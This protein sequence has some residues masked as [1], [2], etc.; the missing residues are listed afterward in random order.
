MN[1]LTSIRRYWV[2]DI[3]FHGDELVTVAANSDGSGMI[4]CS[5]D[6]KVTEIPDYELRVP[7]P[8]E[9]EV[10]WTALLRKPTAQEWYDWHPELGLRR[11]E[12][13]P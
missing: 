11:S 4:L 10:I 7:T 13:K 3:V 1:D 9:A 5:R 6:D 8:E 12:G 2:G